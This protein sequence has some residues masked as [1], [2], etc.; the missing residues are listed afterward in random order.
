MQQSEKIKELSQLMRIH[1]IKI[2]EI[3][4]P[5]EEIK[6]ELFPMSEDASPSQP[7][8]INNRAAITAPIMGVGYTLPQ[9]GVKPFVSVGDTVKQGSILCII[10][11]MKVLNEIS[12]DFDCEIL[13]VCFKNGE[14]VEFGQTLFNVKRIDALNV[15]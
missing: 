5:E 14:I 4:N 8:D 12:A 2:L 7:S 6:I 3:R 10:E 15:H 11:V 13:D 1:G 9:G